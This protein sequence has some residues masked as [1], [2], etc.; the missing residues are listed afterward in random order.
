MPEIIFL[1]LTPF[2]WP[3]TFWRFTFDIF[4]VNLSDN[5][6]VKFGYDILDKNKNT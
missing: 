6:G 1:D 4:Q 3:L 5:M 2:P